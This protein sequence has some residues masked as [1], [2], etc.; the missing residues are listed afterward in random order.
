MKIASRPQVQAAVPASDS[1]VP[2]SANER[3]ASAVSV[4]GLAF[5]NASSQP[6]K[7]DTGTNTELANPSG[8]VTTK[9]A[10]CAAS[11]PRTVSATNAKIQLSAKPKSATTPMHPSAP[12]RPPSNRKPTR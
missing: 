12:P 3:A 6:G 5:A 10:D 9:P 4:T 8:K 11:A 2:V 7:V 1:G